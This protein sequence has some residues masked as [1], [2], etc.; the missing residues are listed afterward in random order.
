MK[1][2]TN[3]SETIS[4][5]DCA[6]NKARS[7]LKSSIPV[8]Y[9]KRP[10]INIYVRGLTRV[11]LFKYYGHRHNEPYTVYIPEDYSMMPIELR[12]PW[13]STRINEIVN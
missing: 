8:E 12:V 13:F 10:P 2:L 9:L 7:Y 11:V 6:W 1:L 4:I 5:R 3:E